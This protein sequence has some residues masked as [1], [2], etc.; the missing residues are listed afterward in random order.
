M[1]VVLAKQA[2]QRLS[3]VIKPIFTACYTTQ[4][5]NDNPYLQ[6]SNISQING[7][8]LTESLLSLGCRVSKAFWA[9]FS[10][11]SLLFFPTP[12][13]YGMP[14]TLARIVNLQDYSRPTGHQKSSH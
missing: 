8:D 10:L 12:S 2:A 5:T 1:V 11:A 9:A 3:K 4:Q 13:G 14:F 6:N 7:I